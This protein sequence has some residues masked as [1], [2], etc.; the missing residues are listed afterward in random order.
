MSVI[1]FSL[2]PPVLLL[3]LLLALLPAPAGAVSPQTVA[4]TAPLNHSGS[5]C[6]PESIAALTQR[7]LHHFRYPYYETLPPEDTLRQW[8]S[9]QPAPSSPADKPKPPAITP[10]LLRQLASV[11]Q[12]SLVIVPEFIHLQHN[13]RQAPF[14]DADPVE[15]TY[16]ELRCHVYSGNS[17][18][19]YKVIA[20]GTEEVSLHSNLSSRI[21][22]AW[23]QMESRLP[24][25][26]PSF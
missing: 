5:A 15:D 9:L 25:T 20:Y 6:P 19:M 11:T 1:R 17:Y 18:R 13:I 22:E 7:L 21:L 3:A 10:D 14:S 8:L 26:I 4:L 12:A 24:P 23:D 16:V 2:R